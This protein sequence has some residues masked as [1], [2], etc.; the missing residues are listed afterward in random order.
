MDGWVTLLKPHRPNPPAFVDPLPSPGINFGALDRPLPADT[1][2][3]S[4]RERVVASFRRGLDD[5]CSFLVGAYMDGSLELWEA[6]LIERDAINAGVPPTNPLPTIWYHGGESYSIGG[7]SQLVVGK[8][9]HYILQA[10]LQ[11]QRAMKTSEIE[12]T[13]GVTNAPRSIKELVEGYGHCFAPA[14]RRPNG[15]KGAGG[16]F[17]RVQRA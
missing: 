1:D 11:H 2:L 4:L 8:E 14:I 12:T 5:G 13:A 15:V 3:D 16:Y 6:S 10:F 7:V 17:I 9:E